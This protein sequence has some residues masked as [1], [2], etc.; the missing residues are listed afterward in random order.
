[1]LLIGNG[2]G[3]FDPGDFDLRPSDSKINR[4]PLLPKMDVWTKFLL[5]M[6]GITRSKSTVFWTS[7]YIHSFTTSKQLNLNTSQR[8]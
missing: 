1:M 5:R 7:K 6:G 2:F 3:T 4:V 8:L